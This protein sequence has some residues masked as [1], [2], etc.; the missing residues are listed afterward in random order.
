MFS[1]PRPQHESPQTAP[2][3]LHYL[4]RNTYINYNLLRFRNLL[5]TI[6]PETC[7][8]VDSL[9]QS[10][11]FRAA[12]RENG[13]RPPLPPFVKRSI[14][15]QTLLTNGLQSFVETGTHYGDTPWLF[16]HELQEIWSVELSPALARLAKRRFRRY[17]NVHIV[18]GDSSECLQK[19]IPQLSAPVLFWLDGHYSAGVTAHGSVNCPIYSELHSIL[20]DCKQRY[21][22]L[23]DDARMFGADADYPTLVDLESVVRKLVPN[24]EIGVEHD[25]IMV[26]PG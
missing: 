19:I 1:G 20:K 18:Q 10:V 14:L 26:R 7:E 13:F 9:R 15:K 3:L 23:I 25:M 21:V 12:I 11:K 17:P 6:A 2:P 5:H 22:I 16:R 4:M 24:A 8:L